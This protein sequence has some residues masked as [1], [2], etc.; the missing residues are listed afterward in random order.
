MSIS[1]YIFS[2]E[3]WKEKYSV[4]GKPKEHLAKYRLHYLIGLSHTDATIVKFIQE[5]TVRNLSRLEIPDPLNEGLTPICMA[6]MRRRLGVVRALLDFWSKEQL[7]EPINLAD[8]YGWRPIHHAALTPKIFQLLKENGAEITAKTKLGASVDDL[9]SLMSKESPS[10]SLQRLYLQRDQLIAISAMGKEALQELT[11][12]NNYRDLPYVSPGNLKFFWQS[13]EEDEEQA[14]L[15][16]CFGK[17]LKPGDHALILRSCREIKGGGHWELAVKDRLEQGAILGTYS[18]DYILNA[19]QVTDT[20]Y[21]LE[22]IDARTSGNMTRWINGGWP[23]VVYVKGYDNGINQTHAIIVDSEGVNPGQSLLVDYGPG[24]SVAFDAPQI[25]FDRERM[26]KFFDKGLNWR[27]KQFAVC[28]EEIMP[29]VHSGNL[30]RKEWC[31]RTDL[32]Q[33]IHFVLSSPSAILDLHFSGLVKVGDWLPHF[34]K[35]PEDDLP[36]IRM[37]KEGHPYEQWKVYALL[38]AIRSYEEMQG[39]KKDAEWILNSIGKY[40]STK[41][42][43]AMQSGMHDDALADYNPKQD[44]YAPFKEENLAQCMVLW[45]RKLAGP[46]AL[47]SAELT[48]I[49]S[50]EKFGAGQDIFAIM[51]R[52][53]EILS[54]T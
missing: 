35:H 12:I 24:H 45:F 20:D 32:L 47:N 41:I 50:L 22:N 29:K 30:T 17:P 38:C 42:A 54:K 6:V 34:E 18:G 39:P 16:R 40:S 53:I 11:G 49:A 52:V 21:L 7:R 3:E 13:Q 28:T 43:K 26:R 36:I 37:W 15:Y 33:K 2:N 25:L 27:L 1:P 9:K 14:L 10:P 44:L 51:D 4:E 5:T 31:I 48:K 19:Q 8:R 23:N 46:G